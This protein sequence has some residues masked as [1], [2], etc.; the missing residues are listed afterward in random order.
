MRKT[1]TSVEYVIGAI[2]HSLP[3]PHDAKDVEFD[4]AAWSLRCT[5]PRDLA[6]VAESCLKAMHKLGYTAPQ[7]L[8]FNEYDMKINFESKEND[9]VIAK[10]HYDGLNTQLE[11]QGIAATERKAKKP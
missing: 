7:E 1:R 3:A 10:L 6:P 8:A 11:L 2:G 4:D 5:V 9:F